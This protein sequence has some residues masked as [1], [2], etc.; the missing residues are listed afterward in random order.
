MFEAYG[1]AFR[2]LELTIDGAFL[3]V[4]HLL[5]A[6]RRISRQ[7]LTL[8]KEN[9]YSPKKIDGCIAGALSW[10]ARLD[11]IAAG[12]GAKRAIAR[13]PVRLR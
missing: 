10:Q 6:R 9:E 13:T 11:C 4:A 8:G 12:I 2:N 1:A 7:H 3:F 5:N